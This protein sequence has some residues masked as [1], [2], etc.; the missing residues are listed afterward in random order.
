MNCII[1]TL[2]VLEFGVVSYFATCIWSADR[3]LAPLFLGCSAL[4]VGCG[5]KNG[6]RMGLGPA[7][8]QSCSVIWKQPLSDFLGFCCL[9]K[10]TKSTKQLNKQ[11]C[12]TMVPTCMVAKSLLHRNPHGQKS[13]GLFPEPVFKSLSA[14][15]LAPSLSTW[16]SCFF[17]MQSESDSLPRINCEWMK[18][19]AKRWL[20]T[21]AI[22]A[23]WPNPQSAIAAASKWSFFIFW[24][25]VLLLAFPAF[26]QQQR[27]SLPKQPH[28]CSLQMLWSIVNLPHKTTPTEDRW[29]TAAA[30]QATLL[31]CWVKRSPLCLEEEKLRKMECWLR[32]LSKPKPRPKAIK[33]AK[34]PFKKPEPSGK[35]WSGA[36]TT[37]SICAG[38]KRLP[39]PL[40]IKFLGCSIV[41][42]ADNLSCLSPCFLLR[43]APLCWHSFPLDA[44]SA[45]LAPWELWPGSPAELVKDKEEEFK[46]FPEKKGEKDKNW[47]WT[48]AASMPGVTAMLMLQQNW[49]NVCELVF[50]SHF[51][52]TGEEKASFNFFPSH[53]EVQPFAH[54]EKSH[55]KVP[56][57][58]CVFSRFPIHISRVTHPVTHCPRIFFNF[59]FQQTF[60][61]WLFSAWSCKCQCNL[62]MKGHQKN[63]QSAWLHWMLS[64]SNCACLLAKVLACA[65]SHASSEFFDSACASF[66]GTAQKTQSDH[67]ALAQSSEGIMSLRILTDVASLHPLGLTNVFL[68]HTHSMQLQDPEC[69][70]NVISHSM[71]PHGSILPTARWQNPRRSQ[72]VKFCRVTSC[73]FFSLQAKIESSEENCAKHVRREFVIRFSLCVS[74]SVLE[75]SKLL[76]SMIGAKKERSVKV[77]VVELSNGNEHRI[78]INGNLNIR[79]LH[80]TINYCWFKENLLWQKSRKWHR[81]I[82]II[83]GR[84]DFLFFN[85]SYMRYIHKSLYGL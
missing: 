13:S 41:C 9:S 40:N 5:V 30:E 51:S 44:V 77:H 32:I 3:L 18:A 10:S 8:F 20:Q 6:F 65:P 24:V 4:S 70:H 64:A 56:C 85:R 43:I 71:P 80:R 79:D 22:K 42:T 68:P 83:R 11:S 61:P 84:T 34:V 62:Q 38:Q 35:H 14:P 36:A 81:K 52:L 1:G 74:V 67:S 63:L 12:T 17:F 50:V 59:V 76:P 73:F 82:M 23:E 15:T 57:H 60:E 78:L 69:L 47:Q 28:L 66:S 49:K 25:T 19:A 2:E 7:G 37:Q 55:A 21:P 39:L 27:Q 54:Q 53:Q 31:G 72:D 16:G 75:I 26:S 46:H 45:Q 33:E 48:R 29:K 58:F